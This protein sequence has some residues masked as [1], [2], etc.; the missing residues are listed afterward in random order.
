MFTM[1]VQSVIIV[2]TNPPLLR[3]VSDSD[4]ARKTPDMDVMAR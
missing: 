4:I 2:P 3:W 1:K